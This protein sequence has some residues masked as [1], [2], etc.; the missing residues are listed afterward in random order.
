M[1]RKNTAIVLAFASYASALKTSL[2][3]IGIELE[4]PP[5]RIPLNEVNEALSNEAE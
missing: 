3:G 4:I 5:L 2:P 1:I